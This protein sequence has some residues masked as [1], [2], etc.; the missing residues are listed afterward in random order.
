MKT[1]RIT[2]FVM[3]T[4]LLLNSCSEEI[5]LETG[6]FVVGFE[7]LSKNIL[8]LENQDAIDLIYSE[9]ATKNGAVLIVI[10][11]ENAIYGV[12]FSTI[13][14]AIDNTIKLY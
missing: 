11:A 8:A 7:S 14:E 12:D 6:P 1:I 9:P 2:L 5:H 3:S 4:V 13:P 10:K